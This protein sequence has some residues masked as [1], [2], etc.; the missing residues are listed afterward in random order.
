ME[1]EETDQLTLDVAGARRRPRSRARGGEPA[2]RDPV[3]SVQVDSGLAHLDHPLE[4]RVPREL[5]ERAQPG[6]RVKVPLAGRD[7][8]GFVLERRAEAEH[9]GRLAALRTVVSDEPVLTPSSLALC[10]AVAER[11]A[12]TLGD[13]LRLAIPPRHARAEASAPAGTSERAPLSL[14]A[15][16]GDDAWADHPAGAALLRR[17]RDGDGPQAAWLAAPGRPP[18]TDWPAA[19]AQLARAAVEGGRGALVL[20]PDAGDLDRAAA[21]LTECLGADAVVRLSADQGPQARYSAWLRALR[22]HARCVVGTRAAAFAPVENLGLVVCWDDGD[23]SYVEPRSPYPHTREVLALR[24]EQSG[25]ALVLG[26]WTRSVAAQAWVE[27]GRL[28][29]VD[30]AQR[31]AGAPRVRVAGDDFDRDRHGAAARARLPGSAWQVAREALT[32]GPVLVQVPRRGYLPRVSCATCRAPARCRH[33]AGPLGLPGPDRAPQCRWCGRDEPRFRCPECDGTALR[34]GTVG[35]SRTAEELGRGFPGVPVLH[36]DGEHRLTQV[37]DRPA[38]VVATPGAEPR[39]AEGYRAVLLLDAWALLER[40]GLDAAEEAL[41]R[42]CA[43]SALAAGPTATAVL[44]G[45]PEH[46]TIPAVEALVRWAP[47]WFAA[48]E[49]A[50]RRELGQPPAVWMARLAGTEHVLTDAL[51]RLPRPDGVDVLG[52]MPQ[53]GGGEREGTWQALLRADTAHAPGCRDSLRALR[54]ARSARKEPGSLQIVV[55]PD[56]SLL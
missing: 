17:V 8:P 28:R 1:H 30:P 38:L 33:C 45:A 4:Y 12:G 49:L 40:P 31:R 34:S 7:R 18:G 35:A 32:D 36:S 56:P 47:G 5:D 19:I 54:M 3:A 29:A 53:R 44:C 15:H 42:W 6:V 25:A 41:R 39:A 10:R 46:E 23:D 52:P 37:E 20:V 16:P 22:G 26:G 43:A 48:R 11:Y 24:A 13:V 55:D 9:T 14:P 27:E 50:D 2:E 21:A 51:A